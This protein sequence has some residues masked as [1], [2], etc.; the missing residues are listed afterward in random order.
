MQLNNILLKCIGF[1]ALLLHP[2]LIALIISAS[3]PPIPGKTLFIFSNPDDA[4][5]YF[6]PSILQ[7]E[8]PILLCI[9]YDYIDEIAQTEKFFSICKNIGKV[10]CIFDTNLSSD[11]QNWQP[12]VI[13]Q[14]IMNYTKQYNPQRIFTL[15]S[16]EIGDNIHHVQIVKALSY[17]P[18]R[19]G[20][21]SIQKLSD[22]SLSYQNSSH[23]D[24]NLFYKDEDVIIKVPIYFLKT[25]PLLLRY[26]G[27]FG[28]LLYTITSS[29][30]KGFFVI[31]PPN[32][33]ISMSIRYSLLNNQKIDSRKLFFEIMFSRY[34][35]FNHFL[36]QQLT[37]I[38]I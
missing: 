21:T 25:E 17:P 33:L 3:L 22:L 16:S 5:M 27:Y 29:V 20:E 4:L 30:D 23:Q 9:S 37:S 14:I 1:I 10:N 7:S 36:Q 31:T 24:I 26:S 15:G 8:D 6:F 35:Y 12:K 32:E 28:P 19:I 11:I 34:F 2:L 38:Q 13:K 18:L